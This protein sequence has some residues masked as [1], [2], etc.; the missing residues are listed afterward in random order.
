MPTPNRPLSQNK[1]T[2]QNMGNSSFDEDYG[3]NA[4]EVLNFDPNGVSSGVGGML[5]AYPA[6]PL[7]LKP[8]DYASR[9]ITNSTT[10]T[11]TFK[12]GGSSG[13]VTNTLVI[14]YTDATLET[15]SNVTKA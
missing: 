14:V 8:Y 9:A 3:I 5:R 6:N 4:V 11:W 2:L 13:A 12:S 15:I 7:N 10:I 1:Y